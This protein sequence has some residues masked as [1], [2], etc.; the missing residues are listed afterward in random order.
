MVVVGYSRRWL[1]RPEVSIRIPRAV[2]EGLSE[3]SQHMLRYNQV[4]ESL[5]APSEEVYQAFA[6]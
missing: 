3:K 2:W 6:Y 5:D 4:V 1:H